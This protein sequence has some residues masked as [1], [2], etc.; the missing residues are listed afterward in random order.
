MLLCGADLLE[1]M[2]V[3]GVW[4]PEHVEGILKDNGVVC[5]VRNDSSIVEKIKDDSQCLKKY[6]NNII[7][8][9]DPMDNTISSSTV[10][11]LLR[12]GQSVR[13]IVPEAVIE[14]MISNNVYKEDH[15]LV[16]QVV[17]EDGRESF[18]T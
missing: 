17:N 10:R 5:L 18:Q 13:Y 6:Q 14:Y 8:I 16:K 3:E 12:S 9:Q 1:S 7:L 4:K 11:A 2:C 15:D